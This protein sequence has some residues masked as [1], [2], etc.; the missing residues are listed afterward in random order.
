VQPDA[1]VAAKPGLDLVVLVGGVVVAD[2]LQPAAGVGLGDLLE[3][4]QELGVAVAWGQGV[5]DVAGGVK[6]A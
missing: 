5:G 6:G 1:G 4:G 2:D 3:E